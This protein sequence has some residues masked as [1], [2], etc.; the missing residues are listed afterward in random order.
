MTAG[1][2]AALIAEQLVDLGYQPTVDWRKDYTAT[3]SLT[4]RDIE[5]KDLRELIGFIDEHRADAEAVVR[6]SLEIRCRGSKRPRRG[7]ATSDLAF[8]SRPMTRPV[9]GSDAPWRYV[10]L[11][12]RYTQRTG[13]RILAATAV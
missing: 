8:R 7:V 13:F 9:S 1:E 10:C 2:R 4:A 12:N 5:E 6:G 3:V 11:V